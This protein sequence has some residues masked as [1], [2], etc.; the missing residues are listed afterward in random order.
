MPASQNR[1]EGREWSREQRAE[2][3][4]QRAKN[5]EQYH[6]CTCASRMPA[7]HNRACH[8]SDTIVLQKCHTLTTTA[9][10]PRACLLA[11]IVHALAIH[12]ITCPPNVLPWCLDTFAYVTVCWYMLATIVHALAIHS[13]TCP[14]NV[15]PWC[16]RG[17]TVVL[18]WCYGMSVYVDHNRACFSHPRH[19][20]STKS[21]TLLC[22]VT[23]CLYILPYTNTSIKASRE[24][25]GKSRDQ[26]AETTE[27][28]A[29]T[30]KQRAEMLGTM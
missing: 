7:G 3:M 26:R 13:I 27:V 4:E 5:K 17:V 15:L 11:T 9:L 30:R 2:S 21:V 23:V 16:N 25:R 19:N 18:H 14:P 12:S 28:R 6:N 29:E 10:A 8:D 1:A 20:L 22:N 24:Y